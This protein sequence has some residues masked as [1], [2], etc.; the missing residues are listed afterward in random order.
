MRVRDRLSTVMDMTYELRSG[1]PDFLD[2]MVV[3]S[4]ATMA[5][6]CVGGGAHGRLMAIR[7]GCYCDTDIPDPALGPRTVKVKTMYDK[8]RFRPNYASKSELPIFMM[9]E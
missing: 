9:R 5:F 6:D 2:R 3:I 4:F 8:D 1:V 7:N